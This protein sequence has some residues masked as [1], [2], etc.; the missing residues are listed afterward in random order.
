MAT[1]TISALIASLVAGLRDDHGFDGLMVNN[2]HIELQSE[3]IDQVL[4]L[5]TPALDALIR[6]MARDG[7]SLDTFARCYS[8]CDQIL[9]KAG[10]KTGVRWCGGLIEM[11]RE[12]V[13]GER[14][15]GTSRI[16][17]YSSAFRREQ[18]NEI[19]CRAKEI[20]INMKSHR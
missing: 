19:V 6:E 20:G 10:H 14:V 7:T 4:A 8:A 11:K 5:G 1:I 17:G 16:D 2:G 3:R 12:G 18:I 9:R 13:G 15:V